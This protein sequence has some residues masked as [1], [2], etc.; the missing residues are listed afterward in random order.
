[1]SIDPPR[2]K[3]AIN[4]AI[5]VP[6]RFV[7]TRVITFPPRS[8]TP[9]TLA[10]FVPRPRRL[11][12]R[13]FHH[14]LF[15]VGASLLKAIRHI[16]KLPAKER[17]MHCAQSRLEHDIACKARFAACIQDC[18]LV[19]GSIRFSWQSSYFRWPQTVLGVEL[20]SC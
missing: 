2:T 20:L 15:G 6:D 11:V 18:V 5:V 17:M 3:R 8:T 13:H 14:P 12:V 10:F 9:S 7:M 1:M 16:P 19:D 4:F